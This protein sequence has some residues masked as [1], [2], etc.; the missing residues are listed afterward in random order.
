MQN[1]KDEVL[2]VVKLQRGRGTHLCHQIKVHMNIRDTFSWKRAVHP[3]L[4]SDVTHK[5][6]H[7]CE[8]S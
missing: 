7:V 3:V 8:L 2:R 5:E 1:N 6:G 4:W